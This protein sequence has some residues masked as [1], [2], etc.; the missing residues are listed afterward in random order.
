MAFGW[1]L[2]AGLVLWA[3]AGFGAAQTIDKGTF[4][5]RLAEVHRPLPDDIE[6]MGP[7]LT[8]LAAGLWESAKASPRRLFLAV[9]VVNRSD[10]P[11]PLSPVGL[12]VRNR[13][14]AVAVTFECGPER[15]QPYAVVLPGHQVS[16]LCRAQTPDSETGP[17]IASML[18]AWRSTPGLLDVVAR[19]SREQTAQRLTE[20]LAGAQ[21]QPATAA[22]PLARAPVARPVPAYV[23]APAARK[24]PTAAPRDVG[25]GMSSF[26]GR[27]FESR[28]LQLMLLVVLALVYGGVA[29]V[30]GNRQAAILY[31][32]IATAY[33][34]SVMAR[35]GLGS[36]WGGLAMLVGVYPALLAG[37]AALATAHYYLF[38]FATSGW[39][40]IKLKTVYVLLGMIAFA[41]LV[42]LGRMGF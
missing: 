1:R 4:D 24:V 18:A 7:Q 22:Q 35:Q 30:I 28:N 16:Y 41:F 42:L 3:A 9:D 40:N 25:R 39:D 21:A 8:G 2:L 23:P 29:T 13:Q 15:K 6:A 34:V 5:V 10:G 19:E 31:W 26:E 38:A 11:L 12:D 37:A 32:L 20:A 36:G 33:V 27:V 14:G 17:G